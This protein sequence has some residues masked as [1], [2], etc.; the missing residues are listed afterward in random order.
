MPT[1]LNLGLSRRAV[2]RLGAT[3]AA[4]LL[5]PGPVRRR[6][7]AQVASP[8]FLVLFEAD[9]GWDPTQ[10]FDVH[11]PTDTTDGI[12]VDNPGQPPSVIATVGGLTYVSNPVTRPAVDTY[13]AN[14]ANRTAVVNGV[15]TR[16]TSHDQSRQLVLTGY[17]D[18]TRAD[19]A[20]MSAHHNGADLPLPHLLVSGA[21]FAGPYAGLSGRLGGAMFEAV[22][23]ATVGDGERAFSGLGEAYIQQALEFERLADAGGRAGPITGRLAEFYDGNARGDTLAQLATS[24]NVGSN[25]P[26]QLATTL[27]QAFRNGLTTSVTVERF[28]GFDTHGDN[29]GQ[30]QSFENVFTFLDGFLTALAAEPGAGG[31]ASLLDQ[32]TVVVCS[33]FGRTPRLNADG[34]KD[35]HPWDSYLLVGKRVRGGVTLGRTDGNQ[36]GVKVNFGTGQPADTGEIIDVVNMVAGIVTLVGANSSA[37]LPGVPP[38]T[39]VID[40]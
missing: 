30:N 23:Y 3:G 7:G 2:L 35:H 14:W 12:D 29:T 1:L 9:G 22:E 37:Y 34:G 25:D 17:L 5:V 32:T 21:S 31:G 28:G 38:F 6:A 27:G 39:A 11:D 20:V 13:F 19:F 8:H 26:V 4:V 10:V 15:N 33:E 16:S 40:A 36:E 24:V 18:P